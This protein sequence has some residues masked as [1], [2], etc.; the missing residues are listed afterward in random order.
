MAGFLVGFGTTTGNGCTSGHGVCGISAFRLRSVFATCAFMAAGIITAIATDTSSLLPK[1]RNTLQM[2]KAG[3]IIVVC[4]ILCLAMTVLAAGTRAFMGKDCTNDN[5]LSIFIL[6]TGASECFFGMS[7]G[8]ALAVSNMTLLSSTIAFLNLPQINPALAFV[9][10]SAIAVTAPA[11]YLAGKM[12]CPFL[13]NRFYRPEISVIDAKLLL[14]AII[15]GVGWGLAG[16]CPGPAI[17]NLG[18]GSIFPV[19][20]VA[21]IVCGMWT[22]HYCNAS[23][24][25]ALEIFILFKSSSAIP[26]QTGKAH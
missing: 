7:F 19:I 5:T 8:L 15:F 1:F 23:L 16:A 17:V 13:E 22:Q 26:A 4:I 21:S 2:D 6:A 3:I 20:Y 9:M 24:T 10:I 25:Q 18:S 14:G 12:S 11:Y